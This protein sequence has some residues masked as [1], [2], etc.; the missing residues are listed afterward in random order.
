MNVENIKE[1]Y[2]EGTRIELNIMKG[3]SQMPSGLKGTVTHVDD[4]GQV[5]IDWDNGSTLALNVVEDSFKIIDEETKIKVL[6]IE[7]HKY[8][9]VINLNDTLEDMQKLVGGDIE[10]YMPFDDDVA[11]VCNEEGKLNGEELNRAIYGDDGRLL[12]IIA[13]KF[14]I[15]YAPIESERFLSMPDDL[16]KKYEKLFKYPERISVSDSKIEVKP[17]KP[18]SKSMER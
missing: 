12:D 17:Y 4:A 15:C 13:G 10:E 18:M 8:P 2:T 5:H 6:F 1:K 16:L 3:E 14:F 9:R 7:P 11:I